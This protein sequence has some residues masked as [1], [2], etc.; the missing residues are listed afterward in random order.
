MDRQDL[1]TRTSSEFGQELQCY[2]FTSSTHDE[3]NSETMTGMSLSGSVIET[4]NTLSELP[5]FDLNSYTNSLNLGNALVQHLCQRL[6]QHGS[7]S[8]QM[9]RAVEI[10]LNVTKIELQT[11]GLNQGWGVGGVGIFGCSRSRQN[12]ADSL[13]YIFQS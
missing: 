9:K 1:D 2:E 10:Y 6:E 11:E 13:H 12:Y 5:E 7:M 4:G 3:Q 8:P